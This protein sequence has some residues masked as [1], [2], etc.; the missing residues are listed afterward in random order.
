M[1]S[2]S[3][4]KNKNYQQGRNSGQNLD[5]GEKIRGPMN[6]IHPHKERKG[7]G[8]GARNRYLGENHF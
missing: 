5:G 2:S 6:F 4:G 7:E 3:I 1:E 8:R